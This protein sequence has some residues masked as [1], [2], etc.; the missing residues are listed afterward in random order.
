MR[1]QWN[2]G[3]TT[4]VP[5][6]R[7]RFYCRCAGCVDEWTRKR[8]I[9]LESI[10]DDIKPVRVEAVGRYAVQIDWNDGHKTGIYPFEVLYEIAIDKEKNHEPKKS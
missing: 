5:F 1:I 9:T 8:T 6:K 2:G 7:L 3:E 4:I 10:R